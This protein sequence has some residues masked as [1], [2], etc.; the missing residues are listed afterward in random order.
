M[1]RKMVLDGPMKIRLINVG[2]LEGQTVYVGAK[3]KN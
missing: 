1:Y 2:D 3:T